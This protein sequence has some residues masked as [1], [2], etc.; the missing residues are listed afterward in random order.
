[1]TLASPHHGTDLAVVGGSLGGTAC[2]EACRQLD[3]DSDLL[4]D[5][6]ADDETPDGPA[7]VALWTENDATVVPPS[8]GALEGALSFPV[9]SVCAGLALAHGEVP[10]SPVVIAMVEAVLGRDEPAVPGVDAC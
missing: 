10:R 8:S 2:P 3:P 7:W 6:N 9:Q 1:M 4:R 5:L